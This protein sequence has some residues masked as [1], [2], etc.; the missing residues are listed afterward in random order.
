MID[1]GNNKYMFTNKKNLQFL[2]EFANK[3]TLKIH[4]AK[5]AQENIVSMEKVAKYF[6]DQ[7]Y[8]SPV[9][10]KIIKKDVCLKNDSRQNITKKAKQIREKIFKILLKKKKITFKQI[11]ER[12][13][14][15]N[16]ST[17]ALSNHF[18]HVRHQLSVK[19]YK[20]IKIKNG[21]YE[22]QSVSRNKS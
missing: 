18:T 4:Y 13:E 21:V 1:C 15:E 2:I 3:F 14:S 22:L 20:V 11:Q 5:T 17:S 6:C 10:Y 19:G 12:F 9:E 7:N 8:I 16:I